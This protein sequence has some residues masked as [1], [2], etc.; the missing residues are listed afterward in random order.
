MKS[1]QEMRIRTLLFLI[2]CG[3]ALTNAHAQQ[4]SI[5]KVHSHNDYHQGIPFWT[6]YIAGAASIEADI[7]LLDSTLFVTHHKREI[8]RNRTLKTLYL[9]PLN[10]I[11]ELGFESRP[12]VLLID[13]KSE[14][15]AT[16]DAL[17]TLL[18]DYPELINHP[19]LEIIISGSRPKPCEFKNY[20]PF[21]LFDYQSR[22]PLP[23]CG[24]LEKIGMISFSFR[25]FSRW[26][27]NGPLPDEDR[28]KL[29]ARIQEAHRMKKSIR[30]WATPD[31]VTAWEVLASLGVDYINTDAPMQCVR[32]FE[33]R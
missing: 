23:S 24:A 18:K 7:F 29:N 6:A 28:T 8:I 21:L 5:P 16:L 14:P 32:F 17:V 33:N 19:Q 30:F 20:P 22:E 1:F 15:Y 27:G 3:V 9:D 4:L 31:T 11:L 12:L 26:D 2:F 13:V 10:T 25:T